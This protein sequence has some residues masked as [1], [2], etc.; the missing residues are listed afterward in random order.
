MTKGVISPVNNFDSLKTVKMKLLYHRIYTEDRP[1]VWTLN[2]E[3]EIHC[4]RPR[5]C[6]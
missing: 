6:V 2:G 4:F 3:I 5:E 1:Q